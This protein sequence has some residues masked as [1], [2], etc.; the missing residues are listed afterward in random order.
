MNAFVDEELK[1]RL[2]KLAPSAPK[3][4]LQVMSSATLQKNLK[5]VISAVGLTSHVSKRGV[6]DGI[7]F[8]GRKK[9]AKIGLN[10][11]N[12]E[13]TSKPVSSKYIYLKLH[14]RFSNLDFAK[15]P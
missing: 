6:I 4:E 9:S 7:V 13:T 11:P 1:A 8:F 15:S 12:A 3:L 5:I 2:T 14:E 10:D